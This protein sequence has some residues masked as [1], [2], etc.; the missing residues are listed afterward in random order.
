M[1]RLTFLNNLFSS[2][3]LDVR[4]GEDFVC[5][6]MRDAG[7]RFFESQARLRWNAIAA[8]NHNRGS[9]EVL[10]ALKKQASHKRCLPYPTRSYRRYLVSI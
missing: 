2:F 5:S 6:L 1:K 8:S 7:T 10:S 3:E 9:D 4:I